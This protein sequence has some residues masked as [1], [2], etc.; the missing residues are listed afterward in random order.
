MGPSRP[1]GDRGAALHQGRPLSERRHAD[2]LTTPL[3]RVG[4]K[5]VG[6]F[7]PVSWE[8]ALDEIA[9]KLSAVVRRSGAEAIPLIPTRAPWDCSRR[10]DGVAAAQAG[11]RPAGAH[12]LPEAGFEG[13]LYTLGA[14]VGPEPEA[15]AQARLD[16]HLGQQHAHQQH[17]PVAL[18]PAGAQ[19]RRAGHR[20]RPGQHARAQAADR[21]IG[22]NPARTARWPWP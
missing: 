12:H 3:R 21:W 14:A 15:F 18:H 16:P 17:A 1:P 4:P 20:H 19:G 7:E 22:L 10:R 8:V 6:A 9:A 2:R 13:M 5:G 11:K